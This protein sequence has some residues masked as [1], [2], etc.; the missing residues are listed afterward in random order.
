M[1]DNRRTF[2][3]TKQNGD[4]PKART[5]SFILQRQRIQVSFMTDVIRTFIH[6]KHNGDHI[7]NKQHNDISFC[8]YNLQ[9]KFW[10]IHIQTSQK[11]GNTMQYNNTVQC[12]MQNSTMQ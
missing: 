7:P 12:K 10:G 3:Y 9:R 6:S 11:T 8:S 1:A 2:I 4:N 5:F